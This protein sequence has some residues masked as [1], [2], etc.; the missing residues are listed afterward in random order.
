MTQA[1][2]EWE[3]VSYETGGTTERL[4]LKDGWLYRTIKEPFSDI[5]AAPSVALVFVPTNAR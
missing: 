2:P 1:K 5:N 3:T 4:P